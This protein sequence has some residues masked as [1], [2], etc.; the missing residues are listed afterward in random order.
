MSIWRAALLSVAALILTA[1]PSQAQ[2]Q[3]VGTCFRTADRVV[4]G[5]QVTEEDKRTGHE[6]CQRAIAAT[7]SIVQKHHLQ[8]A[9]FDIVGRPPKPEN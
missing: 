1:A 9:D 5:Q 2:V 4:E 6:A 8:E 3:D 7:A